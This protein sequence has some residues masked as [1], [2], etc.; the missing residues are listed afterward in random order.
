MKYTTE[1]NESQVPELPVEV[2]KMNG[3]KLDNKRVEGSFRR[4]GLRNYADRLGFCS[5]Y[6][7][8]SIC[9][10]GHKRLKDANFCHVRLCPICD[11]RRS[12]KQFAQI[13]E[14]MHVAYSKQPE[15]RHIFLTLTCRNVSAEELEAELDKL[16]EGFRRLFMYK[17]V[18]DVV[19]GW[20]RALEITY[21]EKDNTYH[22]HFHVLIAVEPDY[23]TGR[24]YIKQEVWC[25]LWRRA[26]ELN[27][28]P[29]VD[30]R[31][32]K[33]GK[34]DVSEMAEA[35]K[36]ETTGDEVSSI[37]GVPSLGGVVAELAK[38][39]VKPSDI[40]HVNDV[41]MDK[42]VST[43]HAALH[44]RRLVGF[45]GIYKKIKAEL[46]LPDI[47]SDKADL[48]DGPSL[49]CNCPI[50]QAVVH[51]MFYRWNIGFKSYIFTSE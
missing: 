43:L 34:R 18:A 14:I 48:S 11:W 1:Q 31:V 8:F 6:L 29:V 9:D 15:L 24:S 46:A 19:K 45:G 23:F 22:P 38:Y 2:K 33:P 41:I 17:P 4:I 36:A 42:V 27:Y 50:C 32:A 12:E 25:E 26:M 28:T 30:V 3:R 13:M 49:E 21:N 35:G 7:R 37:V 51:T 47:E 39:T 16:F 5:S 40:L 44:H 20:V 10:N